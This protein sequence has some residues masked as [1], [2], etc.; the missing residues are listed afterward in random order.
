MLTSDFDYH[1]HQDLIAQTPIEPRDSSRIL[2]LDRASGLLQHKHFHQIFQYLRPG[3]VMVFNQSRVIP[4]RL[5]GRRTDTGGKVEFLLLRRE[6]QGVW[7]ALAKPGR[8]LKVGATVTLDTLGNDQSESTTATV[9]VEVLDSRQDGI[10]TIRVIREEDIDRFGVMPL[11]PYIHDRLEDPERYQTVYSRQLGSAAAPTAGLHFTQ[12]LL[13]DLTEIGVEQTFVTLHVGLDTFR[14]VQ[15]E[16]PNQHRIHTEYYELSQETADVLNRA[17]SNGQRIIAVG[18]TSVRVLEH[19]AQE[20]ERQGRDR[21]VVCQGQAD[22]FIL[23]GYRF[24]RVDA[25]ITNFHLPRST[26]LMLVS[27]FAGRE[28]MLAAYE[29]AIRERYRFFSFG[30]AMLIL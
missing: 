3:D 6:S 28:T 12:E 30:D 23:P 27:A 8:R 5:R 25:M 14:P 1:L 7:Q 17:K 26:L 22:I 21:L 24:R 15:D 9:D 19:T 18:T 4:A 2:V 11:P 13:S 10:K 16:D 20:M 29:E